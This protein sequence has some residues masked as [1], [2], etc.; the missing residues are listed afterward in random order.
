MWISEHKVMLLSDK[1]KSSRCKQTNYRGL[2]G[3]IEL[4]PKGYTSTKTYPY[5]AVGVQ[6]WHSRTRC[7]YPAP[8]RV[9]QIYIPL[10]STTCQNLAVIPGNSESIS[11]ESENTG[12]ESETHITIVGDLGLGL[13]LNESM[14]PRISVEAAALYQLMQQTPGNPP[15]ES[16]DLFDKM[17]IQWCSG[18]SMFMINVQTGWRGCFAEHRLWSALILH[19]NENKKIKTPYS[20]PEIRSW[21]PS[22]ILNDFI[23]CVGKTVILKVIDKIA[24]L[25]FDGAPDLV[26]Y[27]SNPP[28]IWFVEVK[29]TTDTFRRNQLTMIERLS[30]IQGVRCQIC[31]PKSANKR[32]AEA[33]AAMDHGSDYS[34]SDD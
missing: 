1:H 14:Q 24:E 19:L 11:T 2:D 5:D 32:L 4:I 12:N 10:S 30:K 18:M 31:G 33:M 15:N 17:S 8:K 26:L 7:L 23:T 27:H 6:S 25:G 29:S 3:I 13:M 34:D 20:I 9:L 28:I 22:E 16:M 21:F